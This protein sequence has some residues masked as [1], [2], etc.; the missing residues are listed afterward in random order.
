[1]GAAVAPGAR[2][3]VTGAAGGIGRAIATRL[4]AEGLRVVVS[5]IDADAVRAVAD[6]VGA[7]AVIADQATADGVEALVAQAD[8]ALGG[9]DVFF[10][11]AGV[12]WG[13]DLDTPDE[14][15]SGA[16]DINLMSHVRAA[17]LLVPRW[18]DGDGGRFVITASAA[19]LLTM[20]G[21]AAYSASKHAAV[22]FAE[23]LSVM[24]GS[25]GVVVQAICP[26]GV[27]TRM[28]ESDIAGSL[29]ARDAITTEE[30]ADAVWDAVQGENFLILPHPQVADFYARR[31]T[32]TDGWLHAMQ[33]LA[34]KVRTAPR[35]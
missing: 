32:D 29:L 2:A 3:V 4:A 9:I 1:M 15:W 11:N 5:D 16:L 19:G 30:V 21:T 24:Y 25:R 18:V 7:T 6:E 28:I 20:V 10:A 22:A 14:V 27:Q 26:L 34:D 31:A 12:D 33:H 35:P 17:R 8:D 23:W 13:R